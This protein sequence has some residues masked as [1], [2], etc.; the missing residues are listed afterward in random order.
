LQSP[1]EHQDADLVRYSRTFALPPPVHY[2]WETYTATFPAMQGAL[3]ISNGRVELVETVTSR[4]RYTYHRM[5][6]YPF[7]GG[8]LQPD[9]SIDT[10]PVQPDPVFTITTTDGARTNVLSFTGSTTPTAQDYISTIVGTEIA[11]ES[12]VDQWM[13]NIYVVKTRFVIAK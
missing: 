7:A 12:D 2:I 8:F 3:L 4:V 13:G 11:I 9:Y 10:A 6:G 1:L 5:E